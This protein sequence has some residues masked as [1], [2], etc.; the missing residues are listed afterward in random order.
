MIFNDGEKHNK[1]PFAIAND[2][3]AKIKVAGRR[4]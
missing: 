3:P 1:Y 2:I 4:K